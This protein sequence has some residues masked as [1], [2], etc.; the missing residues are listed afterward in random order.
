MWPQR[1]WKGIPILYTLYILIDSVLFKQYPPKTDK[2]TS[3]GEFNVIIVLLIYLSTSVKVFTIKICNSFTG[4]L[5]HP[6]TDAC[7]LA[8]QRGPCPV[9]EYLV[10]PKASVIPVCE[11]N[12]CMADNLV[13]WQ[14][15]CE[16]L[17]AMK[18]CDVKYPPMALWVNATTLEI[19]CVKLYIDHPLNSVETVRTVCPPGCKRSL[20]MQCIP[21][22]RK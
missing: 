5:Y 9:G 3:F 20:N 11:K 12:P 4:Y 22:P 10:L 15:K 14:G 7:W 1:D 21:D 18:P 2:I 17:G 13:S 19:D 6:G 16:V 8:Y